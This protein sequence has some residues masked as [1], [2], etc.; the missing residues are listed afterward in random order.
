MITVEELQIVLSCD[1][2]TAEKALG[3]IEKKLQEFGKRA[4]NFLTNNGAGNGARKLVD[5][6]GNT[7]RQAKRKIQEETEKTTGKQESAEAAVASAAARTN[8]ALNVKVKYLNLVGERYTE[9]YLAAKRLAELEDAAAA[10]RNS[11]EYLDRFAAERDANAQAVDDLSDDDAGEQLGEWSKLVSILSP[12]L[13]KLWKSFEAGTGPVSVAAMALKAAGAYIKA[14]SRE[15]DA[16]IGKMRAL[17]STVKG[18]VV[19]AFK[20]LGDWLKKTWDS[21]GKLKKADGILGKIG[22][23]IKRI[24]LR[25]VIWRSIN[26]VFTQISDGIEALARTSDK[27][28]ATMTE[29][30]SGFKYLGRTIAAALMPVLT[31]LL[32]IITAITNALATMFNYINMVFSAFAGKDTFTKAVKTQEDY[33]ASL[34]K[35][36]QAASDLKGTLAGFDKL[37]IIGKK[38]AGGSDDPDYAGMFGDEKVT[39]KITDWV[40]R[41]KAAFD[42]GD[43]EGV[44][45]MIAKKLTEG[46]L[47]V[48]KWINETLRPKGKLWAQRIARIL[49]GVAD[50]LTLWTTLGKTLADG[51]NA[52]F[53]IFNTFLTSA[54]FESYGIAIGTA[55]M[56]MIRGLDIELIATTLAN[57]FNSMVQLAKGLLS[58]IDWV[59]V[60]NKISEFINTLITGI[61]WEDLSNTLSDLF[62]GLWTGLSTALDGIEWDT[63]ISKVTTALKSMIEKTPW[64]EIGASIAAAINGIFSALGSDDFQSTLKAFAEGLVTMLGNALSGVEWEDVKSALLTTFE[65]LVGAITDQEFL[66]A[67]VGFINGIIGAMV[68]LVNSDS[69]DKLTGA[70][71]DAMREIDWDGIAKVAAS[72]WWE[73]LKLKFLYGKFKL[74]GIFGIDTDSTHWREEAGVVGEEIGKGMEEGTRKALEINSPSKVYESIGENAVTSMRDAMMSKIGDIVGIFTDM[75]AQI[76]AKWKPVGDWFKSNV[77]APISATFAALKADVQLLFDNLW[78]GIKNTFTGVKS[79]FQANVSDPIK[80]VFTGA[81]SGVIQGINNM[82]DRLNR[83]KIDMPTWINE[84]FGLSSI[85]FN[86]PKIPSLATGGL[87]YDEALVRVGEYSNSQSNPEVIAP[88]SKLEKMLGAGNAQDTELLKEQNRLLRQLV[89]KDLIINPSS[90]LG[91]VVKQ[92]LSMNDLVTGN[93]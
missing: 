82:I 75:I 13:G 38:N 9:A 10:P 85:G 72:L 48:D 29:L 31:A 73:K 32:P 22:N 80:N 24:L 78:S 89:A 56:T 58:T 57:W 37:N 59:D 90:R 74:D 47:K 81:L 2:V 55:I 60:G 67:V 21:M 19:S 50:D 86:I 20:S 44:G 92:S 36:K 87:A 46:L 17:G 5:Q 16:L 1:A 33:A 6:Y 34:D 18:K 26:A 70:L 76:E 23:Q 71:R 14:I 39:S 3:Q 40:R 62:I 61:N 69:F 68:D 64:D 66:D 77:S 49:N 52:A 79:W 25:M 88:L 35:S 7:L 11:R 93:V 12:K 4:N 51:I 53:D 15:M 45:G 42:T 8:R 65:T 91:K 54:N 30:T 43:Y 84:K 41:L 83:I 28:N 63:L 27:A